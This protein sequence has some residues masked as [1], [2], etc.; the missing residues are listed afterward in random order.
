MEVFEPGSD[1]LQDA[2][3]DRE[4]RMRYSG[5]A[6]HVALKPATCKESGDGV[7][8]PPSWSR[9]LSFQRS[10]YI[11][12]SSGL[13]QSEE[14][15]D[16]TDDGRLVLLLVKDVGQQLLHRFLPVENACR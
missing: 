11:R 4:R 13:K 12:W 16:D 1:G 8:S 15:L 7:S 2:V 9:E 6:L 3:V 5:G 14:D 10:R